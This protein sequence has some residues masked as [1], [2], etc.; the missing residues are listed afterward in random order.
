MKTGFLSFLVMLVLSVSAYAQQTVVQTKTLDS[1]SHV[2]ISEKFSF[3]L[4]S[5]STC[6]VKIVSDERIAEYVRPVVKNG[7]FTVYLD[8]KKY[9]SELKKELKAKDAPQ[10]VLELEI[11][12]PS[13][14]SLTMK[15][16]AVLWDTDEIKSDNFKLDIS[17]NAQIISMNVSSQSAD[18]TFSNSVKADIEVAASSKLTVSV[19]NSADV[20]IKQKG[21]NGSYELK[22]LSS[23]LKSNLEVLEVSVLARGGAKAY[24][25][26]SASL[27]DVDADDNTVIDAEALES[28]EATVEQQGSSCCHVNVEEYMKVSLIGGSTLTFKRKPVIDIQRIVESTLVQADDPKSPKATKNQRKK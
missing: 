11:Y 3:K 8:E 6:S 25:S 26:G 28:K 12:A 7:V 17:G 27:L 16:K 4:K 22:G 15:D 19:G 21:G 9:P 18:F 5:G 10:P 1:F 23:V 13:I 20:T 14:K 2:N 24:L